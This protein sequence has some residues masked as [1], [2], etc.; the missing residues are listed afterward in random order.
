MILLISLRS[1]FFLEYT[2]NFALTVDRLDLLEFAFC[3]Y[4]RRIEQ[5]LC[6]KRRPKEVFG[7][8]LTFNTSRAQRHKDCFV[9]HSQDNRSRW[10]L[11]FRGFHRGLF[12]AR[13]SN[14]S[15]S[16]L[17]NWNILAPL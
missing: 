9:T 16:F 12:T 11:S 17:G 3:E 13:I 2:E 5:K 1:R 14:L 7:S 8:I 4:M 6:E 10:K 15:E